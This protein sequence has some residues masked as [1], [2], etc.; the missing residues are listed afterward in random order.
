LT[1]LALAVPASAS[2]QGAPPTGLC[3]TDGPDWAIFAN[4]KVTTCAFAQE[5]YFAFLSYR[6][7][8][9]VHYNSVIL[10]PVRSGATGTLWQMRCRTEKY[11]L[12][13]V[14]CHSKKPKGMN[15]TISR[16]IDAK[17]N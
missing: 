2:A 7:N 9:T 6:Y 5:T 4:N 16:I 12:V 8:H 3:F 14:V 11:P 1:A 17:G 13:N 15:I 10:I